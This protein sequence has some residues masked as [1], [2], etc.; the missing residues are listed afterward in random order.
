VEIFGAGGEGEEE[1]LENQ[2]IVGDTRL[3]VTR[4]CKEDCQWKDLKGL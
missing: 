2:P 1:E 4:G 3:V